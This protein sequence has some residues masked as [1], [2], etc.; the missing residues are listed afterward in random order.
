MVDKTSPDLPKAASP[1]GA[2]GY[3]IQ[4]AEDSDV[5]SYN[6]AL[7]NY[8]S[9]LAARYAQPNWFKIAAGFAKP[10]LG[11]F[12]A[13]LGS[14]SEAM[15]E[16]VENQKGMMLPMFQIRSQIAQ[17][18]IAMGQ[19]GKAANAFNEW[20]ASDK[21]MDEHTYAYITSMSPNSSV[22]AAAKAAF[23]AE[24]TNQ[25]LRVSQND[26]LVKQQQQEMALLE[27][28][29]RSGLI[30]EDQYKAGIQ[31]IS[32]RQ[33]ERPP[34]FPSGTTGNAS[35]RLKINAAPDSSG[36]A[37]TVTGQDEGK[38]PPGEAKTTEFKFKPSF[39][40]KYKQ[41][42]TEDEKAANAEMLAS[43]KEANAEPLRQYKAL[44][45]VVDP[46]NYPVAMAANNSIQHAIDADPKTY[47]K[48]TNLI[49]QNGGLAA[50]AEKGISMNWNGQ[51]LNI[52]IPISSGLNAGLTADEQ[53]FR[54]TLINNLA[55]SAYYGMLARGIPVAQPGEER[56]KSVIAQ[57]MGI[58]NAPKAIRHQV[59][60]NIAQLKH[61][62]KL[63]EVMSKALPDAVSSGS[64]S[65]HFDIRQQSPDVQVEERVYQAIL[66][67]M[68]KKYH[69]QLK[70]KKQ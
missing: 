69:A 59:Q 31:A 16:N 64:L 35:D 66:D 24:K 62:K 55:T 33:I 2:L 17:N 56:F 40:L 44:Q 25:S 41:A 1:L 45:T 23:D 51:S 29:R 65:P 47:L 19:Q 36:N 3:Q 42:V 32:A 13:S 10:Q 57:E 11:G 14:A 70:G 37:A 28:K 46:Q 61:A 54:D 43:A 50:M 39:V 58:D 15:G 18:K 63:H 20:K 4:G 8:Q 49:R 34:T 21:P 60:L 48:V 7:E 53:A 30:T 26:L 27:A 6:D 5:Q 38:P 9:A 68:A 52:G 12:M 22:A 67:D